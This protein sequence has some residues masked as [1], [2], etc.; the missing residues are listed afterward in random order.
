MDSLVSLATFTPASLQA[1]NWCRLYMQSLTL[2][3]LSTGDGCWLHAPFVTHFS[4]QPSSPFLWPLEQPSASDWALWQSVL[5]QVFCSSGYLLLSPLGH[6]TR[7]PHCTGS[8]MPYNPTLDIL[9]IPGQACVWCSYHCSP[10]LLA[11]H[12]QVGYAPASMSPS[13]PHLLPPTGC[14]WTI[15][16]WVLY[17]DLGQ[18]LLPPLL[19][20]QGTCSGSLRIWD[21]TIGPF[22]THTFPPMVH[23]MPSPSFL[24]VPRVSAMDPTCLACVMI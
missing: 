2:A 16:A 15:L 24:D 21:H 14:W 17:L 22:S 3:D 5:S 7:P 19:P 13:P 1:F 4:P 20:Y 18:P 6:W 10:F 12:L 11:M 23:T 8:F 9:Y